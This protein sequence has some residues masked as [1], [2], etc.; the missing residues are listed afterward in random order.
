MLWSWSCSSWTRLRWQPMVNTVMME[1]AMVDVLLLL[2]LVKN[3]LLMFALV[4]NRSIWLS[5]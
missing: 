4:T 2:V 1:F 3:S 5:S